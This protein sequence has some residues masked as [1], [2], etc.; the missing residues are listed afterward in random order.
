MALSRAVGLL[1]GF[2]ADRWWGD[3]QGGH[4]VAAFGRAAGRLEHHWWADDRRAGIRYTATLVGSITLIGL[5]ADRLSRDRP[6]RHALLTAGATWV[7]LGGRTLEREALRVADHLD[8]ADLPAARIQVARLVGRDTT[9]L[10]ESGVARAAIESL[11]ENTSD[12]VVAPL[13]LGTAFGTGGLL[14]YRAANTLDAMVGHRS[15]RY[16]RFGWASARLDDALNL[17]GSRA[18]AVLAAGLA[19]RVGGYP[20]EALRIWFRDA[21]RHPSPNAGPVEAAFAG[22]LGVRLGGTNVYA[23][24]SEHRGVLGDGTP[25]TATDVRR[26]ARLARA[27]D[28]AAVAV[29]ASA[30]ALRRRRRSKPGPPRRR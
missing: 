3:P 22:A 30:V 28:L 15:D 11:A 24:A 9:A 16:R 5:A 17:P 4:P 19:P 26:A 2:A 7:V 6:L 20:R 29:A 27:V 23:E 1:A 25:P 12:A 18:T 8:A 14:G 13:V 21:S 10:D